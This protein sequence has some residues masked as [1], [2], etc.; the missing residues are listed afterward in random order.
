MTGSTQFPVLRSPPIVEVV[1]GVHFQPLELDAMV[2]GIYWDQRKGDFPLRQ[3]QPAFS[4]NAGILLGSPPMR[5]LLVS[6]DKVHVLQLQHD[7]FFMNW[8]AFA[9]SYP[10]FSTRNGRP[11]LLAKAM[12]EFARFASFCESRFGKKPKPEKVELTKIDLLRKGTHWSNLEDLATVLPLAGTVTQPGAPATR[13]FAIRFVEQEQDTHL[14]VSASTVAEQVGMPFD[15]VRI[16]ARAV[17]PV[18][19]KS[20]ERAFEDANAAVN[21]AFFKMIPDC[22]RFQ[23]ME[24]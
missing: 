6:A 7:R 13:E 2:L 23:P 22:S 5:A 11:G 16:E 14:I 17:V 4:E 24:G 12:D 20:P 3:L 9:E 1:C 21:G 10:R 19:N 18:K 15:A 8:R